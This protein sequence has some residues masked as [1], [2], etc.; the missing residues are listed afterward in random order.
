MNEFV[1]R[2][3]NKI[4]NIKIFNDS[5]A[6]IDGV[7]VKYKVINID[8][9]N[10][11][12]KLND[13][14]Y[15]SSVLAYSNGELV[16]SVNGKTFLLNIKSDL[17]EKA[18]QLLSYSK[19]AD[20]SLIEVKSPMPGLVLK[21]K[22]Q[23]GESIKKGEAVLILEAMKMENEI[24]SPADGILQEIYV[25]EGTAIEKKISLFAVK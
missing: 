15:E 21:I 4:K 7:I 19:N 25:K 1:V 10:M 14:L 24:K 3:N 13:K 23:K 17:E 8:E 2:L 11:L 6:K 22:K 20:N 9:K 18:F 16:I 5:D 12:L